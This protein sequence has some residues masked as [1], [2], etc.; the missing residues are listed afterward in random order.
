MF[1]PTDPILGARDIQRAIAFDTR[2]LGFKLV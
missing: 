1:K 2:P